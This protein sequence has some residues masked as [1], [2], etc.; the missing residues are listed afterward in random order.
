MVALLAAAVFTLGSLNIPLRP[1]QGERIRRFL[2]ALD[3]YRRGAA[4]FFADS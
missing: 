3:D 2:R 1:Q 4:G